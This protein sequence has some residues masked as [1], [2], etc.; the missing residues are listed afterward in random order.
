M[1]PT[2]TRTWPRA[3]GGPCGHHQHGLSVPRDMVRHQAA[4]RNKPCRR[5]VQRRECGKP[6]QCH[7]AA[8]ARVSQTSGMRTAYHSDGGGERGDLLAPCP[9]RL[10]LPGPFGVAQRL[11][12]RLGFAAASGSCGSPEL[13]GHCPDAIL[14]L[15]EPYGP[16]ERIDLLHAILLH[17]GEREKRSTTC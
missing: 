13:H 11:G 8:V 4:A 16:C 6:G 17:R 5:G 2:S 1:A 3:R 10:Q 12:F 15:L 14:G 9:R 7:E